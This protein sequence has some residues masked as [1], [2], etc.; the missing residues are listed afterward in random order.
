MKWF[1]F[2]KWS[3]VLLVTVMIGGTVLAQRDP[4]QDPHGGVRRTSDW[5][6]SYNCVEPKGRFAG[7]SV[8]LRD[9]VLWFTNRQ[10]QTTSAKSTADPDFVEVQSGSGWRG[11]TAQL[12]MGYEERPATIYFSIPAGEQGS[13]IG[14]RASPGRLVSTWEQR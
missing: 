9:N 11:L 2:M 4:A 1:A 8:S 13:G 12:V 14:W 3:T 5:V 7:C 10:G 6:G